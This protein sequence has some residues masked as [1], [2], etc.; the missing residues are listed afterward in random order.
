[1]RYRVA[2]RSFPEGVG[3]NIVGWVEGSDPQLKKECLVVGGHFDHCG[4]HMGILF[5]GANDN[6]SGS[7]VVMEI[8]QAFSR[9]RRKPKRSVVFVLFGGEEM[10][11]QGSG[12]FVEHIPSPFTRVDAMFN[13]DMVGEG[14]G[15]SCSVSP[16]PAELKQS[17]READI[18]VGILRGVRDMRG[19]GGG[20]DYAPFHQKGI[21]CISCVSNGPHLHYHRSGD[22][23]YRINPDVMQDIGRLLYLT[24]YAWAER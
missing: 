9:L 7:A 2:S 21:P 10:G 6:A 24:G 17:L 23:L 19:Q 3:Y 13:F 20:S 15:M 16:E 12:Y 18:H 1:M 22:T 11:L 5:P 8:A 14:D 4:R